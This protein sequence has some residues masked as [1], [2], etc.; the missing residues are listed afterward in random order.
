MNLFGISLFLFTIYC[1]INSPL[2][3]DSD[4]MWLQIVIMLCSTALFFARK[5]NVTLKNDSL[6]LSVIFVLGH[7]IVYFQKDLDFLLGYTD[8][9]SRVMWSDVKI[10]CKCMAISNL[11]LQ[12]FMLGYL[13]EKKNRPSLNKKKYYYSI[14]NI[15]I[16]NY[17]TMGFLLLFI[18][19][20]DKK[21]LLGG[22]G[23]SEMGVIADYCYRF[24]Q[25]FLTA[26]IGLKCLQLR[27]YLKNKPIRKYFFCMRSQLFLSLI[28][29][30][31]IS[32][33]G[34]R[35]IAILMFFVN[36]IA[37]TYTT[38]YRFKIRQVLL[39]VVLL[40]ALLT[41]RGITRRADFSGN[42][43]SIELTESLIPFT[44][45]LSMSVMTL[46]AAVSYVPEIYPYNYGLTLLPKPF[47][48]IPGMSSLMQS[49][50]GLNASTANSGGL[51]T[52]WVLGE[53]ASFGMGSCSIAD[54]YICF[55]V[56]GTIIAFFIWGVFIRY[57]ENGLYITK[58]ASP[59]FLIIAIVVYS[60]A[61]YVSRESLFTVLQGIAYPLLFCFFFCNIKKNKN[62]REVQNL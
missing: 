34:A 62:V 53:N 46:H 14:R 43:S 30:G 32:M 36:I 20:V 47:L 57:I 6:R 17:F 11:A 35:H 16:L 45:E 31:L 22:Y 59:Y 13:F 54:I 38:K 7:V 24:A 52:T 61:L 8:M 37:F 15:S 29:I 44:E 4:F 5:D 39:G 48:I 10:V 21:W 60:Q 56:F 25:G 26:S 2:T 23:K 1:Y 9:S 12:S 58:K 3:V 33:S 40:G 50:L 41:I 49:I 27:E 28:F 55:G 51:I 42:F 18:L 19:F